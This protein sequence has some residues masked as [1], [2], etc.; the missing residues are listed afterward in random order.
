MQSK[1]TMQQ[2]F[3]MV[4]EC[5]NSGL[6]DYMWCRNHDIKGSTFY[7][8]ISQLKRKGFDPP[9]RSTKE[10]YRDAS[11]PDIVKLEIV[12]EIPVSQASQ[13]KHLSSSSDYTVNINLRNASINI[14]NDVNPQVLT[15]L[16]SCL[17][18]VL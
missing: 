13:I 5:R 15:Q 2:K 1:F 18:G 7:S 11:A 12:D 3:D 6:S 8:W 17:G 14:S 4:M 10:S 9:E 16:L